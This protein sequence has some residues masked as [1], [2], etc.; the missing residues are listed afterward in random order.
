M[1][2]LRLVAARDLEPTEYRVTVSV[3]VHVA[4][5]DAKDVQ[6]AGGLWPAAENIPAPSFN[7]IVVPATRSVPAAGF[8]L[9]CTA[10]PVDKTDTRL[11]GAVQPNA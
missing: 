6:L 11:P 3:T 9:A 10:L 2:D 5:G 4:G 1:V 7:Q 8:D